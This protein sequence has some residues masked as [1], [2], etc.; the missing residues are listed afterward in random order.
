MNC[1]LCNSRLLEPI[2]IEKPHRFYDCSCCG[3]IVRSPDTFPDDI[4]EKERY[5]T[6]HNDVNDPRYQAF[7]SPITLAVQA[8]FNPQNT[9]GL[10]F[11]AGTGPVITKV[12]NDKGYQLNLYDPF[13]YPDK[14]VLHLH[15]D[16]IVC[17]EVIEHFH[18]PLKEFELLK[19]LLKPGG[20]LYCMTDIFKIEKDFA[21]WYYK[22]DPTHVIF[23]TEK[24]LQWIQKKMGFN[25]L[26]IDKRLIIFS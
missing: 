11:G 22:N 25:E 20:K 3:S 2:H 12:L 21:N 18:R 15:Y 9:L 6:H 4:L 14:K 26:K 16:Y 24:S 19:S 1:I 13:F 23:Y 10:D 8:D 17:C 5:E 7:V